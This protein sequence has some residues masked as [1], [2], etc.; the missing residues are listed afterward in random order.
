M[1]LRRSALQVIVGVLFLAV[2][3]SGLLLLLTLAFFGN[4]LFNLILGS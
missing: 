1:A 4:R 3:G 2:A